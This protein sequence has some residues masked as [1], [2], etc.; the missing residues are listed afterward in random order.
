MATDPA[1][2]YPVDKSVIIPDAVKNAGA[3]AD[4]LMLAAQPTPP[5]PP[6][7][8]PI[9]TTP[10]DIAALIAAGAPPPAGWMVQAPAPGAPQQ[11]PQQPS[12]HVTQPGNDETWEQRYRSERGRREAM[13]RNFHNQQ[14]SLQTQV[15]DLMR[16]L[17]DVRNG[18]A[19]AAPGGAPP[20]AVITPEQR[21]AY[22]KEWGEEMTTFVLDVAGKIA[23]A[24][25]GQVTQQVNQR[26]QQSQEQLWQ[27]G[28]IAMMGML[29]ERLPDG[30]GRA[31][32]RIVNDDPQF[33]NW[34]QDRDGYSNLTRQQILRQA[35]Q[36]ND[37]ETVYRIFAGY[38]NP[39]PLPVG[40]G[41]PGAPQGGFPPNGGAP[42]PSQRLPL[43][44]LAAP[45]PTRGGTATQPGG[46]EPNFYTQSQIAKF[47]VDKGRGLYN[48][49]QQRQQFAAA[50][51]VDIFAAQREGRVMPG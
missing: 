18:R 14:G 40:Q 32:W 46:P 26:L 48:D 3:V 11:P 31:G 34:L 13:E 4:A 25:A 2:H 8:A 37:T 43:H 28:Q 9:P 39:Q 22:V 30:Q 19:P 7:Q 42:Q 29:D 21:A 5:A 27:A 50:I 1:A 36:D 10:A 16:Q 38:M 41:G 33:G 51:E 12:Q 49:T 23:S 45:G 24:S 44:S 15:N 35:W 47:F 17:D 6:G 20:T